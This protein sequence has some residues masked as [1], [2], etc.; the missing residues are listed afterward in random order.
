[1]VRTRPS[2]FVT[3]RWP[4]AAEARLRAA[5]DVTVNA[6]DRP[7]SRQEWHDAM[8]RFDIICPTVSDQLDEAILMTPGSNV[9]LI[10]N[11]GVGYDHIDL[12]AAQRMGIAVTNTPGVLTEATADLALT[13]ILMTSRRAGE[14]ERELRSGAWT[15]WR[16]THLMGQELTGK[17]L[18]LVGFGR[19][20]Q[21]TAARARAFGMTIAYTGRRR[22]DA[23][24]EE[25][26]GAQWFETLSDLAAQADIVSLHCPGGEETR[27]LIDAH[28]LQLMKP[29]AILINTARGSVVD[30]LALAN[31]LSERRLW[32][33]GL[34]V[35]EAEPQVSE[36]LLKLD[37]AVLLPHL[38]SATIEVRN[39]MGMCAAAN[40]EAYLAGEELPDRVV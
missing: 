39:R 9:R 32:A 2:L 14:G 4:E 31:A 12:D 23:A 29:T 24:I 15:G 7:L 18:G 13:L 16:P 34:D 33:A 38:G 30:E 37:N 11:Y 1:M 6:S 5:C 17:R 3:R 27:H 35:F 40:V 22:A 10:A 21:A 8:L 25:R 20:A 26:Y 28:I 19:I 36:A